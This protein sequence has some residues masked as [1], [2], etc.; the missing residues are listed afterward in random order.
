MAGRGALAGEAAAQR[1]GVEPQEDAPRQV[2]QGGGAG[3]GVVRAGKVRNLAAGGMLPDAAWD[4]MQGGGG[5]RRAGERGRWRREKAGRRLLLWTAALVA[6]MLS[7][8]WQGR[9]KG[10]WLAEAVR[11]LP[12]H[13][14]HPHRATRLPAFLPRT[15]SC[16]QNCPPTRCPSS[17]VQNPRTVGSAPHHRT[18]RG[19]PPSPAAARIAGATRHP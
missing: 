11:A 14:H 10:A 5:R 18:E 16:P 7:E 2:G 12:P 3:E 15:L 9:G 17:N 1:R 13:H 6:L 19:A 4:W 8:D